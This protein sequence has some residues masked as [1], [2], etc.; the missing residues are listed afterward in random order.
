MKRLTT[1]YAPLLLLLLAGSLSAQEYSFTRQI[2]AGGSDFGNAIHVDDENN[3]YMTGYFSGTLRFS[4]TTINGAGSGDI[5]FVKYNQAGSLQWARVGTSGGWNGGRGIGSDG[6]GNAFVTGRVQETA[7]FDGKTVTS[8]GGNDPFVAK[9]SPTGQILWVRNG[10]GAGDDWAYDVEADDDGNSYATGKF[11]GSI[12]FDGTSVSASG[13]EDAFLVGYNPDGSVRWARAFGGSG[14]DVGYGVETDGNGNVYVVG[15]YVGS[16]TFGSTTINGGGGFIASWD[17]DGDLRWAKS[18]GGLRAEKIVIR[19]DG[20]LYVVGAF[21]GTLSVGET[22]LSSAGAQDIFVLR[23]NSEG[24]VQS[25]LRFGGAG[26]DGDAGF[27]QSSQV[28]P[29]SDGGFT[30]IS[31]FEQSITLGDTTL[32]SVAKTDI[33]MA[34]F[35][36][37]GDRVWALSAGGDDSDA[38]VGIGNDSDDNAY[39]FG[40]FFSSTFTIGQANFIRSGFADMFLAKIKTVGVPQPKASISPQS[41]AFGEISLSTRAER[42]L[43]IAP[44]SLADLTVT[45]V[46]FADESAAEAAGVMLD[47]APLATLPTT[48]SSGDGF[49]VT[50]SFTPE[51]KGAI[52]LDLIVETDDVANPT[53]TIAVSG[54]GVDADA[55]PTAI[56][57]TDTVDMGTIWVGEE[58]RAFL[59]VRPGNLVPLVV[60]EV[61]YADPQAFAKGFEIVRPDD[62]ELPLTVP[63]GDS[64]QIELLFTALADLPETTTLRIQTDDPATSPRTIPVLAA[65]ADAPVAEFSSFTIAFGEIKVGESQ[66]QTMTISAG[67]STPVQINAIEI[68]GGASPSP[69]EL[70]APL[71]TMTTPV[72]V[73]EGGELTVTVRCSPGEVAEYS[74]TLEVS[75]NDPTLKKG[76]VSLSATGTS[77][78]SVDDLR[79]SR[80]GRLAILPNPVRGEG[81]VRVVGDAKEV[82]VRILDV[83]GQPI[84]TLFEGRLEEGEHQLRFA[85]DQFPSGTY[86]VEVL[87]EGDESH[88]VFTV[89]K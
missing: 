69:F 67:N 54:T 82:R 13:G 88:R 46:R 27:G 59:T 89:E 1:I 15:E 31:S 36:A 47:P 60:T 53:Q 18:I 56:Y 85:M 75:T 73:E 86:V 63:P 64:L 68:V 49:N 74:A 39:V 34:R 14:A 50:V 2:S 11:S 5:F 84:L 78:N 66:T 17:A 52:A 12:N 23:Y 10:R 9:Y 16:A 33:V 30:L 81:S 70:G 20:E 57:S 26:R 61:T 40:N 21:R 83:L 6:D 48:L 80:N 55:L 25:A 19:G 24:D 87:R 51:S 3:Y 65:G 37:A 45:S 72:T 41:I 22:S 32:Q 4:G 42:T 44:G 29:T 28:A 7:S 35:S 76:S 77:T 79:R 38:F 58:G 71:D 43:S 8:A 62:S